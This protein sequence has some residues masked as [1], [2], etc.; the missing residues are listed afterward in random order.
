MAN[1]FVARPTSYACV[2]NVGA[3]SA[4]G[5]QAGAGSTTCLAA[6][7]DQAVTSEDYSCLC[8]VSHQ[9]IKLEPAELQ[10]T[11]LPWKLSTPFKI[12]NLSEYPAHPWTMLE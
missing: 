6:I 4:P 3:S 10:D 11:G 1:A 7:G 12:R 8:L 5:Y 9:K 2:A